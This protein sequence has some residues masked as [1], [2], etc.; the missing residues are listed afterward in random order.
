MRVLVL[1]GTGILGKE[2]VEVFKKTSGFEVYSTSRNGRESSISFNIIEN[3]VTRL[4][5]QIRPDLVINATVIKHWR[6]GNYIKNATYMFIVNTLFPH[7]LNRLAI[8]YG[9]SIIHLSTNA[10]FSGIKGNYQSKDFTLPASF[11]GFTKR[12]GEKKSSRTLIIR[13]SFVHDRGIIYTEQ[14][15]KLVGF[16]SSNGRI[17]VYPKDRWNGVT[18]SI[19]SSL[20]L[21]IAREPTSI[22][23]LYHF[24]PIGSLSKLELLSWCNR[25]QWNGAQ[26]IS[27]KPRRWGRKLTLIS[28]SDESKRLWNLAG[29]DS[30]PFISDIFT[31]AEKAE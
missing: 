16:G 31:S 30:V 14:P 29:F 6:I 18:H 13:T 7:Q 22:K 25:T 17:N 12:L 4:I 19:L 10:V 8:R 20:I 11:Y 1:G 27:K 24:V 9:F 15:E 28:D 3:D 21:G 23:G 5:E 2:V 26:L